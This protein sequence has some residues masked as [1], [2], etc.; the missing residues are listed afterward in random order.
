MRAIAWLVCGLTL[1]ACVGGVK[2]CTEQSD[3]PGGRCDTSIGACVFGGGGGS[4]GGVGGGTGAGGGTAGGVGGGIGGGTGGSGGGAAADAG[5]C[6]LGP[7]SATTVCIDSATGH[8]C[9]PRFT[10][11]AWKAPVAAAILGKTTA[12]IPEVELVAHAANDG[13]GFPAS[14]QA[15]LPGMGSVP[16]SRMAASARYVGASVTG[17][18]LTEGSVQLL[19][20]FDGGTYGLDAGVG[21]VVDKTDPVP[22]IRIQDEPP[23]PV[24]GGW[25]PGWRRDERPHVIVETSNEDIATASLTMAGMAVG[26]QLLSEC[27]TAGM[28]CAVPSR[29][30]CFWA[31]LS[32]PALPSFT[33]AFT[34]AAGVTDAAG[35]QATAASQNLAVTRLRWT[36]AV[37]GGASPQIKSSPVV[38][39]DGYI[40]VASS[41]DSKLITLN[42]DGTT[43]WSLTPGTIEGG[44]SIASIAG[45]EYV[46]FAT[47]SGLFQAV[48]VALQTEPLPVNCDTLT[49][50]YN[51]GL[52]VGS[53][54]G[55]TS[56]VG[57]RNS[58][59]IFLPRLQRLSQGACDGTPAPVAGT[60]DY[61]VA[62]PAA[63]VVSGTTIVVPAKDSLIHAYSAVAPPAN[64]GT[65]LTGYPVD[66]GAV[67]PAFNGLAFRSSG[68]KL[69]GS[70]D[71]LGQLFQLSVT[72]PASVVDWKAPVTAGRM[73]G[74]TIRGGFAYFGHRNAGD[75]LRHMDL[76]PAM[77]TLATASFATSTPVSAFP[78]AGDTELYTLAS[79]GTLYASG[80]T[81]SAS[82]WSTPLGAA[83][84]FASP[85][86]DCSRPPTGGPGILTRPGSLYL[87][88]GN[89][90]LVSVIVDSRRLDAT[91]EWPKYQRDA[92]NSG[93]ANSVGELLN[94]GCP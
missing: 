90:N 86:L 29:C 88:L 52:A 67:L 69:V 92:Y 33:G 30:K 85:T 23:R 3:C 71:S 21:I 10:A 6:A 35:N 16:L 40:V 22:V 51:A 84:T 74:V 62:W 94:P 93:N 54:G 79:D 47:T 72:N 91:A 25:G 53:F 36:R 13:G 15:T 55:V 4:G 2:P 14:L 41:S 31:D 80:Y 43:K 19:V 11:L 82:T 57:M 18:M 38:S 64:L 20:A 34:F 68:T 8:S 56:F 50:T 7:C 44:L 70:G 58:G 45:K 59:G 63:P 89:G 27:T 9:E 61:N 48:N 76:T 49:T 77:P 81:P 78:V 32:L 83:N 65:P 46:G 5:Q 28:T 42:P 12:L 39:K 75:A 60:A 1:S 26:P 73:G 66:L 37:A 24:G 87:P 17:A